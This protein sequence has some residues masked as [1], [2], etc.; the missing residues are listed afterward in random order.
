[1]PPQTP[2]LDQVQGCLLGL[3][4]GDAM[5]APFEGG[6]VERTVWKIIGRTRR[7]ELRWTDDT[8]MTLDV[9][10][11]FIETGDIDSDRL[12]EEF[13]RRYRWSRGYGPGAAR[14]LRRISSGMHW[15]K[16]NRSVYPDGSWGNGAAMRAAV[17]GLIY[18]TRLHELSDAVQRSAIVTHAHPLAVEGAQVIAHAAAELA[19]RKLPG[20]ILNRVA[21]TVTSEQFRGRLDL[22]RQWMQSDLEIDRQLVIRQLGRGIAAHDSCV[23]ALFIALRFLSHPFE[24]M[25]RFIWQCGGDTDTIGAMG[26]ALW[27][28]HNGLTQLPE[29]WLTRL[30]SRNSLVAT[31]NRLHERLDSAHPGTSE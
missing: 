18:S 17:I 22:A 19:N 6:L 26:G 20:E 24:A 16:A 23:T 10:Q 21:Q 29:H 25:R 14:T 5:G 28:I 13:A 27:G 15:S 12:A 31:A 3:A 4:L 9:I 8:Q 2:L 30:E 1:M 7:F 11:T